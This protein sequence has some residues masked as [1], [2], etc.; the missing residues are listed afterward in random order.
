M[1]FLIC[2]CLGLDLHSAISGRRMLEFHCACSC[3]SDGSWSRWSSWQQ[4]SKTCGGGYR[5]RVRMCSSPSPQGGEP[6]AGS[7]VQFRRCDPQP[8][9]QGQNPFTPESDQCQISP[10][11]S[12]EILH[13][14]VWITWLFITCSD[15]S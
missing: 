9:Q 8:C 1:R 12:P 11:A 15:E 10:A 3:F 7:S 5:R 13:H 6:C 4:C 14:T 2:T